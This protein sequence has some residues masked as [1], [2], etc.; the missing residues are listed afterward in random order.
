MFPLVHSQEKLR[1]KERGPINQEGSWGMLQIRGE[2]SCR[3]LIEISGL[4]V[5]PNESQ[6]AERC[7]LSFCVGWERWC[8]GLSS[9]TLGCF[10]I[11]S[12]EVTMVL[13]WGRFSS[14]TCH[15]RLLFSTASA[16]NTATWKA[17]SNVNKQKR[18]TPLFLVMKSCSQKNVLLSLSRWSEPSGGPWELC[19]LLPSKTQQWHSL[20]H[21]CTSIFSGSELI[22]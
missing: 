6:G 21:L 19:W 14:G 1:S 18:V 4:K 20:W 17:F 7:L 12:V 3:V 11:I 13:S 9:S 15:E 5:K 8:L 22:M 2:I 10:S 16:K